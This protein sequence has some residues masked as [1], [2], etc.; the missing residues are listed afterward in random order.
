LPLESGTPEAIRTDLEDNLRT[1]SGVSYVLENRN[2]LTRILPSLFRDLR[3]RP[4]DHYTTQ[5][6][7]NLREL[8][9]TGVQV[10][11][12]EPGAVPLERVL[13]RA[14]LEGESPV[15]VLRA[16][17]VQREPVVQ[18]DQQGLRGGGGDR[19][20]EVAGAQ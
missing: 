5:L 7:Q 17:Q 15:G 19:V 4:V 13:G 20:A 9:P 12:I 6:L 18:H 16:L 1:P 14:L 11:V 3:V 10:V 8:A 2:I